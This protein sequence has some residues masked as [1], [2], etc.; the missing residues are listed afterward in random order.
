MGA[1]TPQ[2][3]GVPAGLRLSAGTN[4]FSLPGQPHISSFRPP[5]HTWAQSLEWDPD[6]TQTSYTDPPTGLAWVWASRNPSPN[7]LVQLCP[8]VGMVLPLWFIARLPRTEAN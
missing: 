1:S 3:W 7:F 8:W 6:M 4:T 2:G 5:A